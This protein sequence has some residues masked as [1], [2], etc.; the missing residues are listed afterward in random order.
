MKYGLELLKIKRK[1]YISTAKMLIKSD[2][3]A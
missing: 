3:L 2:S 1:T